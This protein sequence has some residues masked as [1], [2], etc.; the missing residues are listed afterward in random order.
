MQDT[1]LRSR[2]TVAVAE[3]PETITTCC[4]TCGRTGQFTL[5]GVQ[6][7]PPKVAEKLGVNTTTVM[8]RCDSCLSTLAD[9]H[10]SA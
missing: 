7:W 9:V 5:L 2:S 1:Q 10:L 8:W 6:N 3:L 4:P